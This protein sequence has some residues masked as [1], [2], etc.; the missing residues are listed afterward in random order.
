ME[1]KHEENKAINETFL[2][3]LL[4]FLRLV[5]FICFLLLQV[6]EITHLI[7]CFLFLFYIFYEIQPL[8]I[9]AVMIPALVRN[10]IPFQHTTPSSL[11]FTSTITSSN[12]FESFFFNT[13]G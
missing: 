11:L 4:R 3:T 2:L 10:G 1:N 12:F 6:L 13:G 5:L 7:F 9:G 8:G